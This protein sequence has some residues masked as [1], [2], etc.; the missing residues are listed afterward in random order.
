MQ[1][2]NATNE[3]FL[4]AWDAGEPVW[5]VEMG[6]MGPGY[7]QCIQIMAVEMFRAM[8]TNPPADWKELEGDAGKDRWRA[9]SD[10]IEAIPQVKLV[11]GHLGPSGAQFGAA[12]SI[13][14]KFAMD[15][16]A[17]AMATV[18]EKRHIMVSKDFP[19]LPTL[20]SGI[21]PNPNLK[22]AKEYYEAV[23]DATLRS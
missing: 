11:I 22:P 6:G 10:I 18:D 12:M 7:E 16:Y 14:S 21:K 1:W 15:G 3:Q 2:E 4:K 13:A 23:T 20:S 5:T 19:T 17:K 9:Y 8:I